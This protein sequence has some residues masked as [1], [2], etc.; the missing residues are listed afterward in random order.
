MFHAHPIFRTWDHESVNR[1][2]QPVPSLELTQSE[3]ERVE[4]KGADTSYFG[5]KEKTRKKSS[6]TGTEKKIR[7]TPRYEKN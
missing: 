7:K 6:D 3:D 4:R 2:P 5:R 1:L